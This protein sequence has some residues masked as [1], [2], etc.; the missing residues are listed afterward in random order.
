MV[1][2]ARRAVRAHEKRNDE[3][4]EEHKDPKGGRNVDGE[5][6]RDRP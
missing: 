2:F 3:K 6:Q 5:R 1:Y 4:V